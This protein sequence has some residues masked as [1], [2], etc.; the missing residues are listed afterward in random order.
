MLLIFA[1]QSLL[2][3]FGGKH[4]SHPAHAV[5][6]LVQFFFSETDQ[7]NVKKLSRKHT[8]RVYKVWR[9]ESQ[10]ET[11]QKPSV[12]YI[13]YVSCRVICIRVHIWSLV[14]IH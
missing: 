4:I 9:P 6:L 14:I 11:G 1:L 13:L 5:R 7:R 10:E 8:G 12:S 2:L 3:L